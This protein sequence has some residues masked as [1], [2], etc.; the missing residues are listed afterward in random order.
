MDEPAATDEAFFSALERGDARALEQVL[1]HDFTIVDILRGGVTDRV[2]L[3]RSV[4]SGELRFQRIELRERR[5]R[6]YG[7]TAVIVGRTA[8][9]GSFLGQPFEASSRY[10]HV[11]VG[12]DDLGWRLV[13]AQGT[14][15][16]DGPPPT[17]M[18]DPGSGDA[19]AR[20]PDRGGP[21]A[22]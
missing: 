8:M 11:F 17:D 12:K 14:R 15:I 3:I 10:T 5:V 7:D 16:D 21:R 1:S 20:K 9:T 18:L 2:A 19:D 4:A 6:R 13:S 22:A